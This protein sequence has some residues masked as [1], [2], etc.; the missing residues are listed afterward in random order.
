M[1]SIVSLLIGGSRYSGWSSV[2]ITAS[3]KETAAQFTL[4]VSE[5][6]G[7][8]AG[9]KSWQIR[10]GDACQIYYEDR[11]VLTGFVDARNPS[12]TAGSH[13]V[14][15]QG[16]SKTGDL[17]DSSAIHPG[18]EMKNVKLDTI[19]RTLIDR[20]NIDVEAKGDMGDVFEN[21]RLEQGE[22]VHESLDRYARQRGIIV[23]S[24]EKGNLVLTDGPPESD[25]LYLIEGDN[26]LEGNA[27][28]RADK[29]HSDYR[30]KG[31]TIGTD[32]AH[33]K[34]SAG[35]TALTQDTGVKRYRP[36]VVVGEG[37]TSKKSA[38]GRADWEAT[39]RAG[40][41]L[42]A[43]IT[44]VDWLNENDELWAPGQKVFVK[45]PMLGL[46]KV[47]V[48]QARTLTQDNDSGTLARL[49]LVPGEALSSKA[50]PEKSKSDDIW[51]TTK[52]EAGSK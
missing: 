16:R 37:S 46:D 41:S 14:Q 8:D 28:I 5:R 36:L 51:N 52:P 15:I 20:F 21:F 11:L 50:K 7:S 39:S 34:L 13:G 1:A 10:P 42:N 6:T 27:T 29:R 3:L 25:P 19:A 4:S 30:V 49:E 40:E 26:I 48:V 12:F 24:N 23:T 18:G 22:T 43:N 47:M 17:C 38:A 33:G 2:E 32:Q 31:Q 35:V 45:S 9:W 44:V